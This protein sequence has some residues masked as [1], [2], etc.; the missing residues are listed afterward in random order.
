MVNV[1]EMRLDV[2]SAAGWF[3]WNDHLGKKCQ[4]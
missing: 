1:K 3:H 2:K 4:W